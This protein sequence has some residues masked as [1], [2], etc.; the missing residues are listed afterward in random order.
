MAEDHSR[1]LKD[2][3][4]QRKIIYFMWAIGHVILYDNLWMCW[5]SASLNIQRD[6]LHHAY[7]KA[8]LKGDITAYRI[9]VQDYSRIFI[10]DEN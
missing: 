5:Y 6:D 1:S 10:Y 7:P 4:W 3:K 8:I 2:Q 9:Y